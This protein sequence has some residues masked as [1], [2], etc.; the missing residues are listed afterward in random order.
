MNKLKTLRNI[1]NTRLNHI[2]LK[3]RCSTPYK[4]FITIQI[5][6]D[7]DIESRC[8]WCS[9]TIDKIADENNL[10]TM[11]LWAFYKTQMEII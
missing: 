5:K 6:E 11:K 4:H 8:C 10:D 9:K 7:G 3:E 1:V 2:K